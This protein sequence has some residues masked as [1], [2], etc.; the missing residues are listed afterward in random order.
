[1]TTDNIRQ[2]QRNRLRQLASVEETQRELAYLEEGNVPDAL[3]ARVRIKLKRQQNN[4]DLTDAH[5]AI[6]RA[7]ENRDQLEHETAPPPK[8]GGRKTDP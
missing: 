7:A 4:L 8:R 2:L 3:L 6:L 1:M 5:L